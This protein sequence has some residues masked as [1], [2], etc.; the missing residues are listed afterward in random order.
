MAL[1]RIDFLIFGYR[2]I[3]VEEKY[4]KDFLNELL[5]VGISLKAENGEFLVSERDFRRINKI[6]S[7]KIEYSASE[8]R[9]IFG[10]L[11]RY[12]T[13]YGIIAAVF[14]SL[15]LC[16]FSSSRVWDIRIQGS[17][18]GREGEILKE[19]SSF[20]VAPGA[21]FSK[22]DKALVEAE[23]L[24]ASE[25]V[26]WINI[27]QRGVV[28]YVEVIDKIDHEENAQK[29]GFANVV[30]E[31]DAV[32]EEI[33]VK[34]GVAVVK[35]GQTVKKGE[36]LISGV[37]PGELGGGFCYAEG[38]VIGRFSDK[39]SVEVASSEVKKYETERKKTKTKLNFFDF[40]FNFLKIYSKS[41]EECD[42]IK[43]KRDFHT[44]LGKKIPISIE[45]EFQVFY[46]EREVL[47][48]KDEMINLA[49][50]KMRESLNENLKDKNLLKIKTYGA[51]SG[52]NYVCT[53]EYTV[54]SQIGKT[55]E[56]DFFEKSKGD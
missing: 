35:A 9:G 56:F 28:L 2:K 5:K 22:I 12:K 8:A 33:T 38:S 30:A 34:S 27:N 54:T 19:L 17:L 7:G 39:L 36:I 49:L 31:C 50:A 4:L 29:S 55:V 45:R 16:I 21:P 24:S 43:E 10:I 14:L 44:F 53:T 32:I 41:E 48:T 51:F 3:R 46:G 18:S 42:I 25:N 40:S 37:I 20:G 52:E 15:F 26:S 1:P 6:L 47:Y 13:R 23:M 11:K